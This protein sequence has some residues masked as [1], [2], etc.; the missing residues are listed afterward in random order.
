MLLNVLVLEDRHVE[1]VEKYVLNAV[2]LQCFCVYHHS[3]IMQKAFF[4][5]SLSP[6]G[7]LVISFSIIYSSSDTSKVDLKTDYFKDLKLKKLDIDPMELLSKDQ[8]KKYAGDMAFLS[9]EKIDSIKMNSKNYISDI[10]F[11]SVCDI[12]DKVLCQNVTI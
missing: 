3:F 2:S 12:S 8:L 11:N 1:W 6:Q 7:T 5:F 4:Y 9:K 10:L